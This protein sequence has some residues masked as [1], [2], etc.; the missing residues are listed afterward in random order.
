MGESQK[1][2]LQMLSEGK[3]NV[4]EAQRLLALVANEGEGDSATPGSRQVKPSARYMHVIVEPKPGAPPCGDRHDLHGHHGH[5]VNV[6]V[7]LG[8][9]RAGIKFASL[10][11][12]DTADQ[13]DKAFKEKGF[14]FDIRKLK[15]EDLEELISALRDSEINVDSDYE[16]VKVYAE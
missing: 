11:P 1:K 12:A 6:R 7:P 3:I 2:I 15:D 8:L 14:K 4:D 16:T 10:I 9:I 13:V 5:R